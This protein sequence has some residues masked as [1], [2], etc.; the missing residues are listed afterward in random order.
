MYRHILLFIPLVLLGGCLCD[1]HCRY[2]NLLHPGHIAEQQERAKKFDPFASPDMGPNIVGDRPSGALD[3]T[4]SY[5][6]GK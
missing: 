6:R 2:P 1:P 5:Q 3:P 4:P